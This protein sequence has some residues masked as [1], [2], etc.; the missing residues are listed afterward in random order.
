M[1]KNLQNIDYY[2]EE[3]QKI[4][5]LIRKLTDQNNGNSEFSEKVNDLSGIIDR[6][7]D[8]FFEFNLVTE[9]SIDVIVRISSSG[10]IT[11]ISPSCKDLSGFDSYEIIGKSFSDFIPASRIFEYTNLIL[12]L[13]RN[14]DTIIFQIELKHKDGHFIPVEINGRVLELGGRSYLQAS[15]R[16]IS[17]RLEYQKK[18]ESSE[19]TF[20]NIWDKASDGMILIDQD[21]YIYMCNDAYAKMID[22]HKTE[23]EGTSLS[24]HYDIEAGKE[25]ARKFEDSFK[26]IITR[27]KFE[28]E[29]RL[30]NSMVIDLEI[31]TTFIDSLNQNKYLLCI[32]R[33]ISERKSNERLIRKKDRL[34]Q[35]IAEATKTSISESD[36]EKGLSK[37]LRILGTAAEVDRVYIYKHMVSEETGEMYMKILYEWSAGNNQSQINL[38]LLQKLSYSRFSTLDFYNNFE[39]G[40]SLKF[41]IKKLPPN[42]KSTFV[43]RKIKSILLVPIMIDGEYWGFIGFDDCHYDRMWSDNE[44]SFLSTMAA[45]IG[46]VIKREF[47]RNE[48]VRKNAE[49]DKALLAAENAVRVKSEFLALMSHEIRT[50]MNGVIGMTGLLLDTNLTEEQ[51]E[52]V[53]SIRLSGDQLLVIINDVL[54]FSKIESEKLCIEN[55]PFNLRSCVEASLDLL[56]TRAA[57]KKLDMVY[58]IDPACPAVIKGDGIRLRQILTNLLSN[59]VK[60]TEEGEILISVSAIPLEDER[61]EIQFTVSDTGIGISDENKPELFK[62]FSQLD[63][64]LNRS[65]EGTGLG[66]VISKKL[67]ELMGGRMWVD[68]KLN[69]GSNFHFTI[70]TEAVHMKE[71]SPL[72]TLELLNKKVLIIDDNDASLKNITDQVLSWK[73]IPFRTIYPQVALDLLKRDK[74]DVAII[75]QDMPMMDGFSLMN[76]MR[77]LNNGRNLPVVLLR[78]MT[79]GLHKTESNEKNLVSFINKPVKQNLLHDL[80]KNILNKKSSEQA[81][82]IFDIKEAL[83]A[84]KFPLKILLADDN[85][86]NQKVALKM[87]ERIGYQGDIAFNGLEVLDAVQKTNYDV[88]LMDYYMP[89]MDGI[90]TS[91]LIVNAIPKKNQ[92]AIILMSAGNKEELSEDYK[93][94]GIN[95]F[96]QKPLRPEILLEC[97]MKI[98]KRK[99]T[100]MDK[101]DDAT[102]D[103]IIDEHK[104]NFLQDIQSNDDAVFL[105][106]LIDVFIA[107]LPKTIQIIQQAI[108][109]ED[110][111]E[112][113]F[114]AHKLKG[115]SLTLGMTVISDISV[116]LENAAKAEIFNEDVR[117]LG[118]DLSQKIEIVRKELEIIREKYY[119]LIN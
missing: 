49:L 27:S 7:K 104:I 86:I 91:R 10:K 116:K 76:K 78:M 56:S 47:T 111:K 117:N 32:L 60:F 24:A 3:L 19:N 28:M 4:R 53:E 9:A 73:M 88:I 21:G 94:A 1:K 87:L 84:I 13:F 29:V 90:E 69:H 114:N 38:P 48:L 18:L 71:T 113:H 79:K 35:G 52:Y 95:D 109:D 103:R 105:I 40:N 54:D 106:E 63:C 100:D 58:N 57:E 74:F 61:Y 31:S 75:D 62:A 11:Y 108:K 85:E 97:L 92:P 43:D 55:Q 16:D 22:K 20:H 102:N 36:F 17:K 5:L 101:S 64:L 37:A 82:N 81:A 96:I 34:L 23:I 14:K 25:I 42:E 93:S 98:G 77:E 8:I 50:P 119:K 110:G 112:L 66:L 45:I 59:A 44:E 51:K 99:I 41:L 89:E 83:P 26:E 12:N 68:S 118:K 15:L 80:L 33:D 115:S 30:W 46:A 65:Y 67:T 6:F 70:I 39:K 72:D 107:E 2:L